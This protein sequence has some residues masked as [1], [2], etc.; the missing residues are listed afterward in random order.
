MASIRATNIPQWSQGNIVLVGDA[1][2]A[3][4]LNQGQGV[5]QA[6][7]DIFVLARMMEMGI[8][9]KLQEDIRRPRVDKLRAQIKWSDKHVERGPLG[10]LGPS[11]VILGCSKSEK[12]S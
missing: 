7:Q 3:L 8:P 10:T 4:P 9:L 1:A 5:S 11:L 6:V 12:R 2:H